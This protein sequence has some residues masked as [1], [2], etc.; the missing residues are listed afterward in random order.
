VPRPP[1][2]RLNTQGAV[3]CS[4]PCDADHDVHHSA[5]G[6]APDFSCNSRY[7]NPV[8]DCIG[9]SAAVAA[10][11]SVM[12]ILRRGIIPLVASASSHADAVDVTD[13]QLDFALDYVSL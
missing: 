6:D 5:G 13:R 3:F 11:N 12:R 4:K 1:V 10:P 8:R 2:W 9:T 7:A